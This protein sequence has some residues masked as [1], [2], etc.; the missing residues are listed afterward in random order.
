MGDPAARLAIRPYPS[1]LETPLQ[2][3]DGRRF[4]VR[5]VV[6]E[7]EPAFHDLFGRMTP[8]EVR[9][10]FFAPKRELG[11][12][13]AARMTQLDYDRD[14]AFVVATPEQP[15]AARIVGVVHLSGDAD[16]DRGEFAVM[17]ETGMTGLGLGPLLMR[18]MLDH[19]RAIGLREVVGEVLRENAPML[20]LCKVFR[21]D[22]HASEDDPSTMH[23]CLTL[24]EATKTAAVG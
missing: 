13:M 7:D 21:F 8:E 2:L 16:G 6:P 24:R 19:A 11:H 17:I 14:M 23:T 10:R 20:K 1:R 3:P 9:L 5:P 18:R 4:V 15:G 22:C 12:Q